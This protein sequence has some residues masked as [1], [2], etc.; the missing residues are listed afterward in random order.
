MTKLS[1]KNS[2]QHVAKLGKMKF[3]CYLLEVVTINIL[4][5][6]LLDFSICRYLSLYIQSMFFVYSTSYVPDIFLVLRIK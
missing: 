2:K 4:V 6:N 3:F 5:H 1:L